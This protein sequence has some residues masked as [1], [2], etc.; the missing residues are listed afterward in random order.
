MVLFW[1]FDPLITAKRTS[2]CF[3]SRLRFKLNFVRSYVMNSYCIKTTVC[4]INEGLCSPYLPLQ[5]LCFLEG[6]SAL[7]TKFSALTRLLAVLKWNLCNNFLLCTVEL[8][9]TK[10]FGVGPILLGFRLHLFSLANLTR[11]VISLRIRAKNGLIVAGVLASVRESL[12]CNNLGHFPTAKVPDGLPYL[13]A[14]ARFHRSTAA[15]ASFTDG[16]P[17]SLSFF[18]ISIIDLWGVKSLYGTRSQTVEG[19]HW[20]FLIYLNK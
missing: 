5:R 14:N 11:P 13:A 10:R 2:Y 15:S 1:H 7:K 12:W 6:T 16:Q 20:I 3:W 9:R 19:K 18:F 8:R 4:A 17:R